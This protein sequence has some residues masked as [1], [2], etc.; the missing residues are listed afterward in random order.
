MMDFIKNTLTWF[1]TFLCEE[2][3]GKGSMKRLIM[4]LTTCAFLFA[5]VKKSLMTQTIEDIPVTWAMLLAG[6]VGL[7][8]YSNA[9]N[10]KAVKDE[11][12]E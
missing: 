9:V 2:K 5:Y 10:K 3:N 8:I 4:F 7:N 1:G 11:I 12:N 6:F